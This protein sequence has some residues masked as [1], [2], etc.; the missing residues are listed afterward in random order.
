[1]NEIICKRLEII[2]ISE[3]ED[4]SENRIDFKESKGFISVPLEDIAIYQSFTENQN[5]G[6]SLNETV[7]AK[8]KPLDNFYLFNF[9]LCYYI[10]RLYSDSESFLVGSLNYPA[11]LTR[12]YSKPILNLSFKSYQPV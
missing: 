2:H 10:L 5:A 11:E 7:T 8:M 3:I 1:M 9:P 6:I 4:M 12:N